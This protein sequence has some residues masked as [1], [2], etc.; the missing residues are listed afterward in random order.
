MFDRKTIKDVPID[1]KV[2]LVRVDYN[3]PLTPDG[4]V[5]DDYRISQSLPTI[6]FLIRAKCRIVLCSHLGRPDGKPEPK[7]SLEPAAAR[8]SELLGKPVNFIPKNLGDSVSVAVKALKPGEIL[9]LENLR[10]NPGEEANDPKFAESLAKSTAAS[11]FVQDGFGVAHRAHASTDAITH[12]IPSV[13]GLLLEKEVTTILEALQN[14]KKP[15]VAVLGGAKISDKIKVIENFV[16]LADQIVIGGA[17]ANTFLKYKGLPIGKSVFDTDQK[18]T[19]DKIYEAAKAKS[20]DILL[21]EDVAVSDSLDGERREVKVGEVGEND[22]ILDLGEKSVAAML[23]K[24]LGAG[25]VIW[26]GTLGMAEKKQF[27]KASASLAEMLAQE[28]SQ[29]FSLIGG[30]DTADFVLNWEK[31]QNTQNSFGFVSTGGGASLD[32]MAGKMLPGVE[33]LMNK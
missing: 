3:V 22:Y 32:L 23:N 7:F 16:G 19:L 18:A 6:D 33:A 29:T 21:P 27:A 15:L 28:K 1:G 10:F 8:L 5:A 31:S 11:Y 4:E 26:N 2:V 20:I 9:M 14:P 12:L 24:I 25:S 17:M 13:A 30:G